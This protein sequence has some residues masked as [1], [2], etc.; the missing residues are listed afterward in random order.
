VIRIVDYGMGNLRSVEKAFHRLGYPAH[1]VNDATLIRSADAVV[2]PGVGAFAQAMEQLATFNLDN[3]IRF[4]IESGKPF[5]GICLGLQLLFSES[6]EFGPVQGLGIL[7]GKVRRFA[8]PQFT[9]PR[10]DQPAQLR[11]PHMGWN[12]VRKVKQVPLL[13]DVPDGAMFYFVHSYYPEPEDPGLVAMTTDHGGYFCAAVARDNLFACQFH[14]EKSGTVGLA[15]LDRFARGI[16][17]QP[18]GRDPLG[19]DLLRPGPG[20]RPFPDRPGPT[21]RP[22]LNRPRPG[23]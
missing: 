5:L 12:V 3:A 10:P 13:E 18:A 4:A 6:E 22:P 19:E 23:W 15:L 14:P 21:A 8:G 16:Y 20:P 11:I 1:V 17:G 2:L 9:R 7:K